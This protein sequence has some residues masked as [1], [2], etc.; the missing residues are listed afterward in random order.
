ML[1]KFLATII[2]IVSL[3]AS[4]EKEKFQVLA[5]DVNAKNNIMVAIGDVVIFSPTYYITAQKVIYDKNKETLELFDDVVIVKDN[6]VQTKS[7]YAFLDLKTE[8]SYQK[9][10]MIFEEKNSIWINS[11]DSKKEDA[12]VNID[13]STLSSCDCDDP[14]WSIKS[15]NINYNLEQKWINAYNTRLYLNNIPIFYTPYFGFSTDNNRRTGLLRP[16]F[17]YSKSEGGFY[18]Q[19]IFIAPSHN[20]DIEL[21]PQFRFKRGTGLYGY[22]RYADSPDSMLKISTGYFKENKNYQ[23]KYD[24]RN[25]QHYGFDLDYEKYNLFTNKSTNK[26]DGLFIS[27]NYLNDIEYRN[28][29]DEKV[30]E[31][32][33]KNIES[34]INY[35]FDTPDYF[36]GSYFRYYIDTQKDS[37]AST[38]QELP[39]LQVHTYT[40]PLID[41][42][43]FSSD[44]KYTNYTRSEGINAEQYEWYIPF[45]YAFSLFDD[46]IKV[47]L[48]QEFIFNKYNY[49]GDDSNLF[50]DGKYGESNSIVSIQ[51]DIIKPYEDYLHTVNL[52]GTY[53]K[54]N[55]I[56]DKGDLYDNPTSSDD[57][58]SH[59]PVAQSV[60]NIKLSINQSLYD[61]DN[62]KQIVNHKLSQ[63]I[64]YDE[65]D[66]A[67]LQNM[68]NEILY[69][70]ILGT[71]DGEE[72]SGRIK[73]KL[74]YNHQDKEFVE[75]SSLFSLTYSNYE[76]KLGHYMSEDTPNSGKD[77]L[78]SYQLDLK[79]K[80]NNRYSLGY[81]TSY[82]INEK[83][84]SKQSLIFSIK[85]RC[86]TLDT[87]YEREV[88]ATSTSDNAPVKQDIIYFQLFLKPIGGINQEYEVQKDE[89]F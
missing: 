15:S 28:L 54:T 30:R 4:A 89:N 1:R 7:D 61:K 73:N 3:E 39:K 60:D 22:L 80:F 14:D 58:L 85:D 11:K 63:S 21:I 45:S 26:N 71:I 79:Y 55:N 25:Q 2:F 46:Y 64:L 6:N 66:N 37:N 42:L 74:V 19:P 59:Y 23:E 34:K 43:M 86:W 84:R 36:L 13:K 72:L 12:I 87:K 81:S 24:L 83:L 65:F 29:E 5:N 8:N 78:E 70:Y 75:S 31:S 33:E 47:I 76:M 48:R 27:I 77:D 82:N 62:L 35:M 44:F 52:N 41:R 49:S 88:K 9:P 20:Y 50:N 53:T 40:R 69:N 67:K 16:T 56:V 17:G 18:S 10:S 57:R 38:L 32:S 51:S 68:E